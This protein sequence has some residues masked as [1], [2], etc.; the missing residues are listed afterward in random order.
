M[1]D[2]SGGGCGGAKEKAPP[3]CSTP[4]CTVTITACAAYVAKA[5][6]ELFCAVTAQGAAP[7]A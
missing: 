4:S 1:A 6:E 2:A 5:P 7:L 3:P